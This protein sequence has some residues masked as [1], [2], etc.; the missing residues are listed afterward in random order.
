M[1]KRNRKLALL[2]L[3]SGLILGLT[4]SCK[5]DEDPEENGTVMDVDGNVYHAVTIGTQTWMVE[6]LKTT[7]YND[8]SGEEIPNITDNFTWGGL[9]TPAYCWYNND[10]SNKATYGALYNWYAVNTG[11]LCPSGWHV[12]S[13]E[14]W[15]VLF[16]YLGG[17]TVAGG[18]L[19]EAGTAHWFSPN[20]GADNSTGFTALPGGSHYTDGAFHLKGKYGW[21]WSTTES[22]STDAWHP[23][24]IYNS[25][26]VTRI[27]GSKSIGFSVRCIKD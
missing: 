21:Y 3:M 1:K 25:S 12:P 7:H 26:T 9:T 19:K 4:F 22:T 17:L 6:N 5:E 18:K 10:E 8:G 2:L 20:T 13:D 16:V 15:D 27:A 23:Y 14:E 11:R 24:F